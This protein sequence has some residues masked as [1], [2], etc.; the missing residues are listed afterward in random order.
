[1]EDLIPVG[2]QTLH[3]HLELF[4]P[5]AS[6][7]PLLELLLL[8]LLELLLL[9]LLDEPLDPPSSPAPELELE[10]EELLGAP[11][12]PDGELLHAEARRTHALTT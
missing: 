8:E 2:W 7:P 12:V 11:P 3:R 1:M 10:P 5:P 9:E 4:D 6:S